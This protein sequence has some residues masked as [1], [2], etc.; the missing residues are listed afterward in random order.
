MKS[1]IQRFQNV[2]KL[3]YI[4]DV[5]PILL[6]KVQGVLVI[7]GTAIFGM[8]TGPDIALT[9]EHTVMHYRSMFL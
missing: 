5:R 1:Q 6:V 2:A 4:A 8:F 7:M 9:V 3:G